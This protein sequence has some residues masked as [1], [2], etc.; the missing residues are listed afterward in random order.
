MICSRSAFTNDYPRNENYVFNLP[1]A[2]ILWPSPEI[3]EIIDV[4]C[5]ILRRDVACDL[6]DVSF[7]VESCAVNERKAFL[8]VYTPFLDKLNSYSNTFSASYVVTNQH[9]FYSDKLKVYSSQSSDLKNIK[10]SN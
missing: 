1:L 7:L 10:S 5:F 8:R 9:P 4:E 6:S 2:I 3:R